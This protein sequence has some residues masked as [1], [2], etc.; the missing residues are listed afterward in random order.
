[1]ACGCN[2]RAATQAL[3]PEP[4]FYTTAD[5][6]SLPGS[7]PRP[8]LPSFFFYPEDPAKS[9]VKKRPEDGGVEA[10]TVKSPEEG[11]KA[12]RPP[13]NR[14][15]ENDNEPPVSQPGILPP[16][17]PLS[18]EDANSQGP[19]RIPS[20][21]QVSGPPDQLPGAAYD[22]QKP[23]LIQAHPFVAKTTTTRSP[24]KDGTFA[25][26]SNPQIHQTWA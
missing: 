3:P 11:V 2:S 13:T 5:M 17:E 14:E 24:L 12:G 16:G 23:I 26:V 6:N 18:D 20:F 25:I 7:P 21:L 10:S 1:M 4:A 9:P 19:P 8:L 22:P 15:V